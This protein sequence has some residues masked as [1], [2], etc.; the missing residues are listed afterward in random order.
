M[1]KTELYYQVAHSHLQE[2]EQRAHSLDVRAAGSMALAVAILGVAALII[3]SL[4]SLDQ[5]LYCPALILGIIGGCAFF[6]VLVFGHLVQ[7]PGLWRRDPDL[8]Q[9]ESFLA[10]YDDLT[11]VQWVG[12]QFKK[13]TEANER[14]LNNKARSLNS[15]YI[16]LIILSLTVLALAIITSF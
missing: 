7:R 10:A 9:F 14:T 8:E 12:N 4:D 13:A 3:N 15:A 11:L 16:S 6:G 1:Q 5:W 2:Q